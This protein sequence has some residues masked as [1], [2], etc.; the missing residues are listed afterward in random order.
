[1]KRY[2]KHISNSLIYT[3]STVFVKAIPFLLLPIFTKYLSKEDYGILGTIASLTAIIGIYIGLKPSL[4]IIVRGPQLSKREIAEYISNIIVLSSFLF[5]IVTIILLVFKPIFFAN[6]DYYILILI[7]CMALLN[8]AAEILDTIFQIEKKA[9]NYAILQV[10]KM[11][12]IISISLFLIVY[13][14]WGWEGRYLAGIIVSI[15]VLIYAYKYLRNDGYLVVSISKQKIKELVIYLFPLTFHV[16]GL[17][18]MASIDII[19]LGNM[20]NL[21][22]AGVYTVAYSMGAIIGIVHDALLKVWSPEF[23]KRIKNANIEIKVKLV[24]FTYVYILASILLLTVFI[25]IVP[26]VFM[27]MV[28]DKF[29]SALHIVPII[30]MGLTFESFRKLFIG[31]YYNKGKNWLI[32][33]MTLSS[34][35]INIILNYFLIPI[36]GIDGAAYA[37]VISYCIVFLLT[38]VKLSDIETMPWTQFYLQEKYK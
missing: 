35:V 1:M 10:L 4:F 16:L 20:L 23:Y 24:K 18:L 19:F 7:S 12:I 5:L 34:G 33:M 25:F 32:A 21:E 2:K 28:D 37:T 30:A 29:S 15:F 17:A 22:V 31:Y 8:I 14:S 26:Y 36:Y 38:L 6:L 11:V 27:L 3:L 13:L 9:I